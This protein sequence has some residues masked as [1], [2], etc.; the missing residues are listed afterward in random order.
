MPT[1]P[2]MMSGFL[3]LAGRLKVSVLLFALFQEHALEAYQLFWSKYAQG[4]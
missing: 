2:T 1:L 4:H 3:N